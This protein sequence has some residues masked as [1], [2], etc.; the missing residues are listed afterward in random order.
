MESAASFA[1]VLATVTTLAVFTGLAFLFWLVF[2][3][4]QQ[5]LQRPDGSIPPSR[6][7]FFKHHIR[8]LTPAP[9]TAASS[10]ATFCIQCLKLV[11]SPVQIST[12][13]HVACEKCVNSWRA[14][15]ST[16]NSCPRCSTLLFNHSDTILL[17]EL[18]VVVKFLQ[19]TL[20][21]LMMAF[22]PRAAFAAIL[23]S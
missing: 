13:G 16:Q 17:S 10:N 7:H 18:H 23:V 1:E 14:F 8:Q 21:P 20:A 12:C 5:S 3:P 15:Y 9:T 22:F 4:R 6:S 11:K 19:L 2:F